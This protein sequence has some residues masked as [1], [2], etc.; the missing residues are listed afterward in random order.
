MCD[1]TSDNSS[2]TEAGADDHD[3]PEDS[4]AHH[5]DADFMKKAQE[6]AKKSPDPQ[7]K[8]RPFLVVFGN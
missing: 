2:E 4:S 7:T 1:S 3:H 6:C 8:V 5:N